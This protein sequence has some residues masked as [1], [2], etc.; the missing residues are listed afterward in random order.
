M[1]V[2]VVVVVTMLTY[3]KMYVTI[4]GPCLLSYVPITETMSGW[5]LSGAECQKQMV[6]QEHNLQNNQVDKWIDQ[7]MSLRSRG[8]NWTCM[9]RRKY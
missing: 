6:Q 7:E 4:L 9:F 3:I 5:K 2:V 8:V 1:V